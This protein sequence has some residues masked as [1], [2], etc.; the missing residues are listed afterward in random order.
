M[1][2]LAATITAYCHC[3]E[4]CTAEGKLTANSTR[5]IVGVTIAAPRSVPFGTWV[6]VRV[7]GR[8]YRRRVDD[9]L[10]R[11]HEGKW[12]VFMASHAEAQR[13]GVKRGTVR[14]L[15]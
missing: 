9:R 2:I 7:S 4:C 1:N 12:D 15:K 13:F 10:A 5:P 14:I 8:I 3:A 6:E 11:R